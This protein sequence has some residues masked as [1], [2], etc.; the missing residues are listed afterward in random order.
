MAPEV[1]KEM[2]VGTR[3]DIWSLGQTVIELATAKNPWSE[4]KDL[5]ELV[6]KIQNQQTP[7][8]PADLS[9][10]ATD[11]ISQCLQYKKSKRPTAGQ[12]LEHPFI[13]A[14]GE[15]SPFKRR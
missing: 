4:I 10:E 3:S 12:L 1:I 11:F 5:G 6:C 14:G 2:P 9:P 15:I 7:I 8:L 13:L